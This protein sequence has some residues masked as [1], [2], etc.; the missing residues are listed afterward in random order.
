MP[1]PG[2]YNLTYDFCS[3]GKNGLIGIVMTPDIVAFNLCGLT[4]AME[5]HGGLTC[6]LKQ[7]ATN[8]C[9]LEADA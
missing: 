9:A 2:W 3:A 8:I 6:E 1:K 5:I 4:A 7:I